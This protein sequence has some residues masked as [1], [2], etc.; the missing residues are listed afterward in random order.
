[1]RLELGVLGLEDDAHAAGAEHLQDAIAAQ[2]A[3]LVRLLRRGQEIVQ[4]PLCP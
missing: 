1:M 3:D 4:L 2:P